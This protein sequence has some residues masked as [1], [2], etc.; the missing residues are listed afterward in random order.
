M[1]YALPAPKGPSSSS[2]WALLIFA[3]I[4]CSLGVVIAVV[5]LLLDFQTHAAPL[6]F[7]VDGGFFI[8]ISILFVKMMNL[9]LSIRKGVTQ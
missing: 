7:V 4:G 9:Y 3:L 1:S 6:M 5:F 2:L 8:F